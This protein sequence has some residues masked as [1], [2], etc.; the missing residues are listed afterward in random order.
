[1]TEEVK[2]K[3]EKLTITDI[4]RSKTRFQICNFLI[5]YRELSIL[6]LSKRIGK[7][8]STIYEHLKKM[9]DAGFV[10]VSREEKSRSNIYR[11]Y[12]S[13]IE[14][15]S[16]ITKPEKFSEEYCRAKIDTLRSFA[17]LNQSILKHWIDFL[18]SLKKEIGMG[19][20]ENVLSVFKK[21]FADE[22]NRPAHHSVAFYTPEN[23][24]LFYNKTRLLYKEIPDEVE[25]KNDENP[26]YGGMMLLPIRLILDYLYP[27][28]KTEWKKI[29]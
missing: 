28:E 27:I 6:D 5:I 8:K 19:N 9:L 16:E 17:V 21:T 26:Y 11:K 2:Q 25:S 1:M 23:A 20:L 7:S 14:K 24:S 29:N 18:E 13:W 22:D 3:S 12:Y 10:K 4:V 15:G